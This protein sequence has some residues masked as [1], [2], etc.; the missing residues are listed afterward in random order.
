MTD[1]KADLEQLLK[2]AG[3][4]RFE[5]TQREYWQAQLSDLLAS[6]ANDRDDAIALA[7]L[8]QVIA[9]QRAVLQALTWPKERLKLLTRPEGAP[10]M[11]RGGYDAQTAR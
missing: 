7:R 10:T 3:W 4:L 2:S 6:A 11:S 8:R 9:A 1:E 5:H